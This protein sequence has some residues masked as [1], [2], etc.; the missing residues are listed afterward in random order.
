MVFTRLER[1]SDSESDLRNDPVDAVHFALAAT[2][3]GVV[4]TSDRGLRRI[5]TL[6]PRPVCPLLWVT[7]APGGVRV[8]REF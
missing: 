2:F 1:A 3:C 8:E 7:D 4:A 5:R 6:M